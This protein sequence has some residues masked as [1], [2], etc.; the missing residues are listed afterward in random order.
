[1]LA[2]FLWWLATSA[3]GWLAWPLSAS[4]LPKTCGKGYPWARALGL[5][6]FSY[7]Y[8]LCG[9]L[10][11]LPNST[12]YMWVVAGGFALLGLLCW[13]RKRVELSVSLRQEW[14]HILTVEWL[15]ALGLAL[16]AAHKA[17]DPAIDHTEEPMD[18]AFLNAC[19]RSPRMP[20]ND[21][22]LAGHSISYYYFGYLI[23]ALLTKL[24]GAPA[25]VGYNLGLAHTFAMTLVGGYALIYEL[26][27]LDS[28]KAQKHG[29][30]VRI[31]SLL[32][33]IALL[34]ASNLE[35]PLE[36]LRALGIG[37]EA[38]YR[39][40]DVPGLAEA[41]PS[42]EL[43]PGGAWW[44]WRAS[45][46]T[47]D[48]NFLGRSPTVITEFPAFSFVLGDLHPH[49]M[50]LP[51]VLLALETSVALYLL[52]R[53]GPETGR[54]PQGRLW[55]V[56]WIFGALG[57]LNS[58]DLPTLAL[59]GLLAFSLGRWR[60]YA[61]WR[62]WL[63]DSFTLGAWMGLG[64]V[65]LYLPFYLK[66]RSQA[67]G[68]GLAYY[69][70]TPLKHYLLFFGLW[71][72]P[73]T[74]ETLREL[75]NSLAIVP[76]RR[77]V[78]LWGALFLLPW[79][80]TALLGGWGRLLLGL[81]M[82]AYVGPWLLLLQSGLLAASLINCFRA[83]RAERECGGAQTLWYALIV[84]GLGL[85]YAAEFFYLRDLFDT[86]MNTIFKLYYQ[87]WVLLGVGGV[88]A[89]SRL[90]RARG[91]HRIVVWASALL[92]CACLY[93]PFAAAYTRGGGYRGQPTL[94]GTAFLR[95]ES[96]GEYGAFLW[97]AEH[98]RPEE[99]LVE[100]AGEDY[101]P[102]HNRLSSWTGLPTILGWIGHEAQWRGG[103]EE[104][105]ARLPDL[106]EIYTGR[107]R[108]KVLS[109]LRRYGAI[110]L[111][112]GEHEKATYDIGPERLEWYASFLELV[113]AQ[114][115]IRLYRVPAARPS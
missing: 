112:I 97:L 90:W 20:P 30:A 42:G 18:F 43:L 56:P 22:W 84:V 3:I 87:A 37:S 7:L 31:F 12:T 91:R 92:L 53:E 102:S 10:G 103:D 6:L 75:G 89:A 86:R 88:V 61:S 26:L 33:G 59:V 60:G 8:W 65:F 2:L 17:Y 72:M 52:G 49:V 63:R 57:F 34:L 93:Y 107:D 47:L 28:A 19:L 96:P 35:G 78:S 94:D 55:A 79:L 50:S 62:P 83:L 105:L 58:W 15:F 14:P 81:G 54:W 16:Y 82:L 39:W 106:E 73:I 13:A 70:K 99:V 80:G 68:I 114:G 1:M 41:K 100:A 113:Y 21:P 67:Q 27:R 11:G 36:L 66:L 45:R 109:V 51:Y 5:I 48:R 69:A 32:G 101:Y 77:L 115:D 85:T 38:F 71:L 23:I 40:L 98:A 44:W 25:G 9:V 95:Q 46:I 110:Y 4:A 24:I 104:V 64:S 29:R 111:Y 76:W 108:E 74:A